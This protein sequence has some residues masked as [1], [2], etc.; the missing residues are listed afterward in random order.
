KHVAYVVMVAL[1]ATMQFILYPA[2]TRTALLAQTRPETAAAERDKL[3]A[4]EIR[5]LR[6]NVAA[7][8]IVLLFTAI[9]TAV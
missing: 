7:A 3:A 1:T 6:L 2:M 8:M 4:R 5:Y 9:A